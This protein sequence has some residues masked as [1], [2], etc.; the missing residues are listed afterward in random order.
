MILELTAAVVRRLNK[1]DKLERDLKI[2][3]SVLEV[4]V[5]IKNRMHDQL[6]EQVIMWEECS[7]TIDTQIVSNRIREIIGR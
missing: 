2:L 1:K 4:T 6:E 3:K 7:D 5:S